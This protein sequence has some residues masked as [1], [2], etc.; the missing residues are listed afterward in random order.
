MRSFLIVFVMSSFYLNSC[1][2]PRP[3]EE[4]EISEPNEPTALEVKVVRPERED[5]STTDTSKIGLHPYN[6]EELPAKWVRLTQTDSIPI[7]YSTC[8]GGNRLI[9]IIRKDEGFDLLMHGQQEDYE[10]NI[11]DTRI[12]EA[13][14]IL[15]KATWVGSTEEQE[16]KFTWIDT[17]NGLGKWET[18]FHPNYY[19]VDEFVMEKFE[20]SFPKV[21]QPCIECF[22][23]EDCAEM[24]SLKSQ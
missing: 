8:D 20:Q 14:I 1:N 17:D 10:Y 23:P 15:I 9:S 6:I 22:D 3:K 19:H 2:S 12:T 4:S 13:G 5:E 11:K 21:E 18:T 24:E 7:I 16:F